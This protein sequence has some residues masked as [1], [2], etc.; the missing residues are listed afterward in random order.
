MNNEMKN[1]L[2]KINSIL[3]IAEETISE[4]QT[5]QQKLFKIKNREERWIEMK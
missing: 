5:E 3:D 1:T 4:I 2:N